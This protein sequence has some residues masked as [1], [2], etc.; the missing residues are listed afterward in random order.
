MP[1]KAFKPNTKQ[2]WRVQQQKKKKKEN[3]NKTQ[4]LPFSLTITDWAIWEFQYSIM[5][6]FPSIQGVVVLLTCCIMGLVPSPPTTLISFLIVIK[7]SK[8]HHVYLPIKKLIFYDIS[9]RLLQKPIEYFTLCSGSLPANDK[10]VYKSWE[11]Y[12]HLTTNKSLQINQE[13]DLYQR[14]Y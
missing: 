8:L 6:L 12:C 3:P 4:R 11:T 9:M 10:S 2:L 14:L 5:T 7:T 1:K 13:W